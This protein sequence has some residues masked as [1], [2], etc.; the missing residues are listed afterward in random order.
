MRLKILGSEIEEL[1]ACKE[2]KAG[3][4]ATL[5]ACAWA[6]AAKKKQSVTDQQTDRA[7]IWSQVDCVTQWRKL[8]CVT[9][10]WRKL[11]RVTHNG[12]N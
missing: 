9:H 6:G 2:N 3:Y 10:I 7:D 8:G 5:V 1:Q 11:G 12:E 4:T